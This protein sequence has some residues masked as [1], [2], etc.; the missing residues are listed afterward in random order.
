MLAYIP[1][2]SCNCEL[3]GCGGDKETGEGGRA[4]TGALLLEKKSREWAGEKA[5]APP[6]PL[7]SMA[8]TPAKGQIH[9]YSSSFYLETI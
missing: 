6:F 1:P 5:S 2:A 8:L 3:V 9:L 4:S 7:P